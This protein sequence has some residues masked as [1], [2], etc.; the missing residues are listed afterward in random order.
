[1][2]GAG[3][4]EVIACTACEL[5]SDLVHKESFVAQEMPPS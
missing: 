2:E 5:L 1:M 3:L 4:A